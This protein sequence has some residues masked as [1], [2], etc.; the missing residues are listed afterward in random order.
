M[1]GGSR[2]EEGEEMGEGK[3]GESVGD[4]EGR[5]GVSGMYRQ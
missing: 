5:G 3:K 4:E 2:G 1:K